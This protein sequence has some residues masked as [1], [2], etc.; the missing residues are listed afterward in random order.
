[1]STLN[2]LEAEAG[3]GRAGFWNKDQ[4]LL[5]R[6]IEP[7]F[8]AALTAGDLAT[9]RLA[10]AE[11]YYRIEEISRAQS[12]SKQF[13]QAE[14]AHK[15]IAAL[16]VLKK[17]LGAKGSRLR[18]MG[19]N[20]RMA[21]ED[22]LYL[23]WDQFSSENLEYLRLMV[24][25]H[26]REVARDWVRYPPGRIFDDLE[27]ALR[28]AKADI[29][30]AGDKGAIS[31]DVRLGFD[32]FQEFRRRHGIHDVD[33]T[34]ERHL[35]TAAVAHLNARI[36]GRMVQV[37]ALHTLMPGPWMDQETAMDL[38]ASR[39]RHADDDLG[40]RVLMELVLDEDRGPVSDWERADS[41]VDLPV[42]ARDEVFGS[43]S[44]KHDDGHWRQLGADLVLSCDT[45]FNPRVA[46]VPAHRCPPDHPI[47][48]ELAEREQE[49]L[50]QRRFSDVVHGQP[51]DI[52][53]SLDDLRRRDGYAVMD[54]KVYPDPTSSVRRG[55]SVRSVAA[56]MNRR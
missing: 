20:M 34:T 53:S 18:T 50:E 6:E 45:C 56:A 55:G 4:D 48:R 26:E 52:T 41:L 22:A 33:A 46:R 36:D 5:R 8:L 27:Q 44:C 35:E 38:V 15:L 54:P 29:R 1:M 7:V 31:V 2:R 47:H 28:C 14:D 9:A 40:S 30:A 16:P 43:G 3:R 10:G 37:R 19:E 24:R 39:L 23:E 17:G 11:H 13:Q 32:A 42:K 49:Y 51:L 12:C 25:A 21:I